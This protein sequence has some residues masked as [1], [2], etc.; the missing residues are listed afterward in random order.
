MS[1]Q[2]HVTVQATCIFVKFL[3]VCRGTNTIEIT[4]IMHIMIYHMYNS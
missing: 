1:D 4:N 2:K 3:H